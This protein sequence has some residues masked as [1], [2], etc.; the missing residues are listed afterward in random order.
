MTLSAPK[1]EGSVEEAHSSAITHLPSHLRLWVFAGGILAL[2]L[3]SKSWI[4]QNLAPSET[5]EIIPH[6]IV[7]QRQLNDGAV[8]GSL[9]GMVGLFVVASLFALAFVAVLFVSSSIKQRFLH[10]ALG[11]ILAGA[12]GNL[13]DRAFIHADIAVFQS[14]TKIIGKVV[15]ESSDSDTIRIGPWPEGD[16]A[17]IFP[18]SELVEL[19]H[20]GVVRDFIKFVPRFPR[21][22]PILGGVEVWPWVFNV[23]DAALVVGVAILLVCFW[24]E[25]RRSHAVRRAATKKEAA[26]PVGD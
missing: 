16:A 26:T 5:S 8:F 6:V 24:A 25:R 7:F 2:D 9:T 1:A 14:G 4:F 3:W 19:K 15:E 18:R 22:V 20:Q 13:F 10:I 21:W 11:M 17:R 23:A 12:L